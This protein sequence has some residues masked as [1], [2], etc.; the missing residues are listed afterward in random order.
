MSDNFSDEAHL[1][2]ALKLF[3]QRRISSGK[4]GRLCGMG[5][6]E[7]LL[8]ASRAGVP[9]IDLKGEDLAKEFA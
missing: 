2:L 1:L 8:T 7:F 5:R 4:A 3:E 6:V 9:V